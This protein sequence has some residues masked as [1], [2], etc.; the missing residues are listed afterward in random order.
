MNCTTSNLWYFIIVL[1]VLYYLQGIL[2]PSGI[3][4]QLIILIIILIGLFSFLT[5]IRHINRHSPVLFWLSIL[6]TLLTISFI[7]GPK[8]IYASHLYDYIP[9][10]SQFKDSSVFCLSMF[11]GYR[12]GQKKQLPIKQLYITTII[13]TL[14]VIFFFVKNSISYSSSDSESTTNNSA[15]S[16]LYLAPFI[17]LIFSNYK[18]TS[19]SICSLIFLFVMAGAK[20]GAIVCMVIMAIIV[21]RWYHHYYKLNLKTIGLFVFIVTIIGIYSVYHYYNNEYLQLRMESTLSGNSSGRDSIYSDLWNHWINETS[22]FRALFGNGTAQ[23]CAI[24]GN[25]AHNDWLELLIDNGLIGV[26]VYAILFFSLFKLLKKY[27][28]KINRY[29]YLSIS[30]WLYFWLMKSIFSMGYPSIFGGLC[31]MLMG[32]QIGRIKS[33]IP[34]KRQKKRNKITQ[35]STN[36]KILI[37]N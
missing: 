23:T 34:L 2:Y 11:T 10:L 27:R 17:A 24:A 15:Y 7:L 36:E 4:A 3:I 32:Q 9:T 26:F 31:M 8:I 20:R 1:Y 33:T 6:Y 35:L 37:S 29:S 16:F 19:I 14:L 25:Y 22:I 18:K 13:L 12:I 30:L 21:M 5:T 28:K